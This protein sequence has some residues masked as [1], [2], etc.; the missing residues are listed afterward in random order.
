MALERL[1]SKSLFLKAL[2]DG[3]NLFCGA[4]FSVLAKDKTNK[5]IPLGNTM[6]DE[7]KKMFLQ[8][9]TYTKLS[10]ACTKINK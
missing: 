3:I 1:D 9:N 5:D 8:I 6:L 2:R 4:G 7:L 10:Y